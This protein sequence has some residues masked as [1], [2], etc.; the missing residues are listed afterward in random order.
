MAVAQR[1]DVVRGA[2]GVVRDRQETRRCRGASFRRE[3]VERVGATLEIEDSPATIP[4][5]A[6]D[7]RCC[8]VGAGLEVVFAACAGVSAG[9][10]A[11]ASAVRPFAPAASTSSRG[12]PPM[13]HG[14]L[15]HVAPGRSIT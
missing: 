13:L 2:S 15:L 10:A 4:L 5:T 8:G 7:Q 6:P 1:G 3:I 9:A 14:L 11:A 12:A